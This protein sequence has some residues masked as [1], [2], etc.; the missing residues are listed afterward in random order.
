MQYIYIYSVHIRVLADHRGQPA[1]LHCFLLLWVPNPPWL[2]RSW[3]FFIRPL[4]LQLL[5]ILRV[6]RPKSSGHVASTWFHSYKVDGHDTWSPF[7]SSSCHCC[8]YCHL[9]FSC[10][11]VMSPLWIYY[12]VGKV[13]IIRALIVT[14]ILLSIGL[15]ISSLWL[16][17]WL[18][19]S[20]A[21]NL[22]TMT[23]INSLSIL[24]IWIINIAIV[25]F[26]L[27]ATLLKIILSLSLV[28]LLLYLLFSLL[29][30]FYS[31]SHYCH[32]H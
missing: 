14:V 26:K 3:S 5:V 21:T 31:Y 18:L 20:C 2:R 23:S 8:D 30:F 10:C 12:T 7:T 13:T 25:S 24:S 15:I 27:F 28:S 9:L 19:L 1:S 29:T 17:T 22:V 4:A 6:C 16:S 11:V 32:Y